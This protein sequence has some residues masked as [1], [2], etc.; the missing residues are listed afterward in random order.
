[1]IY[2]VALCGPF[3][4]QLVADWAGGPQY[5]LRLA[6]RFKA[7]T[8]PGDHGIKGIY[9]YQSTIVR[10]WMRI[11]PWFVIRILFPSGFVGVR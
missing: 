8:F 6:A 9:L 4:G 10:A 7:V 11:R 2:A 5:V 1:M 3:F